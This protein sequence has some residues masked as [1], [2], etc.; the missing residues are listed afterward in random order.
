MSHS[1]FNLVHCTQGLLCTVSFH[2]SATL[3][4]GVYNRCRAPRGLYRRLIYNWLVFERL[5]S[6]LAVTQECE[7][8]HHDAKIT[9]NSL[10]PPHPNGSFVGF[11]V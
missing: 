1:S 4:Y 10:F 3:D 2:V 5:A 6:V 8:Y 7:K 11:I 9:P